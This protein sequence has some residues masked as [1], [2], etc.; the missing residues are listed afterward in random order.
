MVYDRSKSGLNVAIWA[1]GLCSGRLLRYLAQ[2]SLDTGAQIMI[3]E[4]Y[5]STSPCM[6]V[7]KVLW[8]LRAKQ[9]VLGN[10]KDESNPYH[11]E[12]VRENLPGDEDYDWTLSWIT[13]VRND[14]KG[15]DNVHMTMSTYMSMT[16]G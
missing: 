2:C 12:W 1:H 6:G 4:K 14:G 10:H 3:T 5:F 8:V 15:A 16:V 11:W 7:A 9:M 13:K